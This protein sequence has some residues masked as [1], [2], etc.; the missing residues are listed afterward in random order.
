MKLSRE[1][2]VRSVPWWLSLRGRLSLLFIAFLAI[3]LTSVSL[4]ALHMVRS[5]WMKVAGE[6]NLA[7]ASDIGRTVE[8]SMDSIIRDLLSVSPMWPDGK[9]QVSGDLRVVLEDLVQRK[10]DIRVLSVFDQQGNPLL[11]VSSPAWPVDPVGDGMREDIVESVIRGSIFIGQV[12]PAPQDLPVVDISIPLISIDRDEVRGILT[13]VVSLQKV[14]RVLESVDIGRGREFYVVDTDG[15]VIAYFSGDRRESAMDIQGLV[16]FWGMAGHVK[17]VRQYLSGISEDRLHAPLV[18]A[19]LRRRKVLG[20]LAVCPELA[21]GVIVEEDAAALFAPIVPVR[22]GI[23]LFASCIFVIASA[24]VLLI[25]GY[26]TAPLV[27][28]YQFT[29]GLAQGRERFSTGC[30]D[31]VGRIGRNL[32]RLVRELSRAGEHL[33]RRYKELESINREFEE[34]YDQLEELSAQIEELRERNLELAEDNE[35]LENIL[36]I[37]SHDLKSPL[38]ILQDFAVI[39]LQEYQDSLSDDGRYYLERIK[40]NAEYMERLILD[41]LEFSKVTRMKGGWREYAVSDIVGRAVEEFRGTIKKRGIEVRVAEVLPVCLCDP[42][43]L[44]Q[45]FMNL[46]SNAVKFIGDTVRPQVEIGYRETPNEHEFFVRDNGIGIDKEHHEKIFVIFQRLQELKD[47][48][49]TGVGLTIV[50][51]IVEDHGGRVWVHSHRGA[52]ATFWFTIPKKIPSDEAEQR[53]DGV[54][55]HTTS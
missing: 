12:L 5:H 40:A 54:L 44:L 36:S 39:L 52:G 37:V 50:K 53:H 22:Y 13:A 3:T 27:R 4:V 17:K 8:S 2:G 18:Y 43:R 6:E 15:S 38:Y 10:G 26:M 41:L 29:E 35:E 51:R 31:E 32:N 28:L 20:V 30:R 33:R 47:V 34:S 14:F 45:V 16:P 55:R 21:W 7:L 1:P 24:A 25:I 23:I 42:D 46:V 11:R 49:G 19:N 48:E 9:D